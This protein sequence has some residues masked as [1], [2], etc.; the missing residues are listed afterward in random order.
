MKKKQVIGPIPKIYKI[1]DVSLPL[2]LFEDNH[3]HY[4]YC[5]ALDIL[6]YGYTEEE[7]MKS[8]DVMLHEIIHSAACDGNLEALLSRY[9]WQKNILQ[10]C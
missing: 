2:T 7:A 4:T 9:G 1:I 10:I 5:A 3:I 8:F 6:G